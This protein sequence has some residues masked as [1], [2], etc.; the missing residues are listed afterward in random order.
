MERIS[1]GAG[2]GDAHEQLP[3]IICGESDPESDALHLTIGLAEG[4]L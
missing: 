2:I 1:A 3:Y 4:I